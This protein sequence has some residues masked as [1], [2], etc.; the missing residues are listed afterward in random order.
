M[1]SNITRIPIRRIPFWDFRRGAA[2]FTRGLELAG[3]PGRWSP[4][5]KSRLLA[6]LQDTQN[7]KAAVA[8]A[9]ARATGRRVREL[10]MTSK[11]VKAARA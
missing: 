7:P 2:N 5:R 9:F 6:A 1:C 4:L 10:P 11:R 8:N 3:T